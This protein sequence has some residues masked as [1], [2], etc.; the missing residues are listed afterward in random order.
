MQCYLHVAEIQLRTKRA[1]STK[2]AL[3]KAI[4]KTIFINLGMEDKIH[5]EV[6]FTLQH[7]KTMIGNKNETLL[8]KADRFFE[9]P[10]LNV[11]WA[12]VAAIRSVPRCN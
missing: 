12:L 7:I 2:I 11:I 9:V 3:K 5:Q 8:S 4:P 10:N 1:I 6:H